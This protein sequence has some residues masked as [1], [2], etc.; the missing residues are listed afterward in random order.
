[1]LIFHVHVH[2]KPELVD[3]FREATIL[4]AQQSIKEP[5][6]V[7]FDVSQQLD[8]PTRF[9]LTEIYRDEAAPVAHKETTH[10]ADWRDTV[11][12]MMAEPRKSIKFA[13]VFPTDRN[14]S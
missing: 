1:M 8:D 11:A 5:G 13:N 12:S 3:S 7:R 4:N 6:V 14:W 2:V 10:Y 9:V